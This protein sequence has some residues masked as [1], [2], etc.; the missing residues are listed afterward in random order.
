M[1]ANEHTLT[2][3]QLATISAILFYTLVIDSTHTIVT[4]SLEVGRNYFKATRNKPRHKLG[5][6]H[7]HIFNNWVDVMMKRMD[8][9]EDDR[10]TL[11]EWVAGHGST[12]DSTAEHIK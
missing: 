5:S 10:A 8:L 9:D 1:A 6:P 3:E 12:L 11:V 4:T 7:V 2:E